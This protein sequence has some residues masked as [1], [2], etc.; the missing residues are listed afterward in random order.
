MNYHWIPQKSYINIQYHSTF[1]K[2]Y[3]PHNINRQLTRKEEFA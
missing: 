2:Q 1:R 3:S